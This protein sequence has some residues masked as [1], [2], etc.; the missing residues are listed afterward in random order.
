VQGHALLRPRALIT[1]TRRETFPVAR[2]DAWQ[3]PP[4]SS[5]QSSPGIPAYHILAALVPG[6]VLRQTTWL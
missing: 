6:G 4:R 1:H 3:I 5:S 2:F